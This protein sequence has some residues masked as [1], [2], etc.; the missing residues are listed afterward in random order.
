MS[1][2]GIV[3]LLAFSGTLLHFG[4]SGR[5]SVS[6]LLDRLITRVLD[7]VV[8]GSKPQHLL[9]EAVDLRQFIGVDQPH[10]NHCL[11]QAV[12]AGRFSRRCGGQV[13]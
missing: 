9:A 5:A 2:V 7:S 13:V 12:I 8:V 11:V 6:G 3:L 10:P 1:D 4:F